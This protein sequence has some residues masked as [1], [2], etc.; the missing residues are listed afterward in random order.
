MP[1]RAPRRVPRRA[2]DGLAA[3]LA[4]ATLFFAGAAFSAGARQHRHPASR[5]G[6]RDVPSW[7]PS[8]PR[9]RPTRTRPQ[10]PRQ[11]ATAQAGRRTT[12]KRR[13]PKSLPQTP[14]RRAAGSAGRGI[15]CPARPTTPASEPDQLHGT[16]AASS[17]AARRLDDAACADRGREDAATLIAKGSPASGQS[18]RTRSAARRRRSLHQRPLTVARSSTRS[19]GRRAG[20]GRHGV[21]PPDASRPDAALASAEAAFART[22]RPHLRAHQGRLGTRARRASGE[23]RAWIGSGV[24]GAPPLAQQP[25]RA[26]GRSQ[27]PVE[28]RCSRSRAGRRSPI[29]RSPSAPTTARSGSE[30]ARQGLRL[31]QAVA[32]EADPRATSGSRSTRAVASTSRPAA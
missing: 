13:R 27:Q 6:R 22:A 21:A 32:L 24:A 23:W 10:R 5:V 25:A 26:A 28:L 3:S 11:Q 31:G 7:R 1:S 29:A 9:P 17:A 12:P 4:F 8:R 19:R 16:R 2:R 14:G 18:A 15:A 30:G 20:R